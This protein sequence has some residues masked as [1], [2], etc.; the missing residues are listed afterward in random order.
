MQAKAK[1]TALFL[2][3]P[4]ILSGCA[5]LENTYAGLNRTTNV[6]TGGNEKIINH[7]QC[8]D[9]VISE[10]L[11]QIHQF[12]K[13]PEKGI[14]PNP[15]LLKSKTQISL[16]ND[17]CFYEN[18]TVTLDIELD[19][20]GKIG[21]KGRLVAT[22]DPLYSYPFFVAIL[23]RFNKIIAKQIFAASMHYT[24]SADEAHYH[25][26]IRQIIPVDKPSSGDNYSV[27][28]GFQL[29]E[30]QLEYNRALIKAEKV[31]EKN[32]MNTTNNTE[33]SETITPTETINDDI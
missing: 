11:S 33:E 25:E 32:A 30:E 31:R 1:F 5:A 10:E 4:L 27:V 16:A 8:P 20:N 7:N 21:P 23:D 17:V 29:S 14:L 12:S 6:I 18:K 22:D 2:C 9:V 3:L 28:I 19:F 13:M 26:S 24:A 15:D